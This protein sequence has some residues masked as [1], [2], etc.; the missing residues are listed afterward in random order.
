[1]R[2]GAERKPTFLSVSRLPAHVGGRG[3]PGVP[4]GAEGIESQR[5]ALG[6][7][8]G[9]HGGGAELKARVD[10]AR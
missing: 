5:G 9:I 10:V 6:I 1:M 4:A 8:A 3:G 2:A 7:K